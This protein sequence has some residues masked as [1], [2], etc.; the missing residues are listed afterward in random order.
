MCRKYQ[1]CAIFTY[2]LLT[3]T[4]RF[5]HHFSS[6]MP[7]ICAVDITEPHTSLR[8]FNPLYV[9]AMWCQKTYLHE[10]EDNTTLY[11]IVTARRC[12]TYRPRWPWWRLLWRYIVL[13]SGWMCKYSNYHKVFK[14]CIRVYGLKVK[15]K[16]QEGNTNITYTLNYCIITKLSRKYDKF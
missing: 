15:L 8:P 16:W 4:R 13:G 2:I 11:D 1:S 7:Y 14:K 5:Y 10:Q 3:T 6:E 9:T 12:E